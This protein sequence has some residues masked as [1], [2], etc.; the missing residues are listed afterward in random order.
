MLRR[1][2]LL[3]VLLYSV[4]FV[5]GATPGQNPTPDKGFVE[6][7]TYKNAALGLVFTPDSKLKLESPQLKGTPGTV[8]LLVTV[9]AWAAAFMVR[10]SAGDDFLC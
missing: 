7:G 2:K 8:P 6:G 9:A 1:Y 4:A 3:G 10:G 5:L